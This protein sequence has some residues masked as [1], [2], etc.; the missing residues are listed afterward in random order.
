M[1]GAVQGV[2][3]SVVKHAGEERGAIAVALSQGVADAREAAAHL[4]HA[5]QVQS[6]GEQQIDHQGDEQRRLQLEAPAD[7]LAA[8]AQR[9]QHAGQRQHGAR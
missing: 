5:R 7:L 4:E 3:T 9:Q 6:H 1:N 8:G 2:A